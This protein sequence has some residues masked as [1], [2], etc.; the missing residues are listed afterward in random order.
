MQYDFEESRVQKFLKKHKPKRAA[1]QLPSGLR[2]KLSEVVE[3]FDRAGVEPVILASSCYGACDLADADAKTLGCDVLVHYGHSDIGLPTCLPTL[4]VESR[5]KDSPM[6]IVEKALSGVKLNRV[7]LLTTVQHIDFLEKLASALRSRGVKTVIGKPGARARYPGQLLGCDWGCVRSAASSVDG[8]LYIGTGR[9]H[10][11]G[12][13]LATGKEVFSV[14]L[15]TGNSS[16]PAGKGEFLRARKAMVSR[17][18]SGER[19]GVVTSTKP[20]QMRLRLAARLLAELRKSGREGQLLAV[21]EITPES[22]G[23]FGFDAFVCA[24]CPRIPV[25]DAD[26]FEQPILTPFEM[27]AMLG[28]V[29]IEKYEMD[30]VKKED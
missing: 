25:D 1:I 22:V 29:S 4:Y 23:D 9:F 7:G 13:A 28:A 30:E 21:D 26:R 11:L 19:F 16:Q 12:A 24:A 2:P 14:D 10:P 5:V 18:A 20:G 3:V 15:S 27:R 6:E 8:Y 17:A